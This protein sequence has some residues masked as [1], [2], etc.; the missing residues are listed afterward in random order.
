MVP[1]DLQIS[2]NTLVEDL[3]A[4]EPQVIWVFLN[5]RMACVGCEMGRF[6]T[7]AE[8]SVNYGVA[9]EDLIHEIRTAAR[10]AV[11]PAINPGDTSSD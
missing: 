4:Q 2:E 1:D 7:L 8:V 11:R 10:P 9:V 6:E 5:R 3:L